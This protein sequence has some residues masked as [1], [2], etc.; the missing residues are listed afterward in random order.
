MGTTGLLVNVF[1]LKT[2]KTLTIRP[3]AASFESMQRDI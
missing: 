1:T 3:G 2:K